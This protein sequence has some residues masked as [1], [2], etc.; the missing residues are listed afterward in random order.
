MGSEVLKPSLNE[1][2]HLLGGIDSIIASF[3][4]WTRYQCLPHLDV[5]IVSCYSV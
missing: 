1:G 2:I 5:L 4:N 3:N